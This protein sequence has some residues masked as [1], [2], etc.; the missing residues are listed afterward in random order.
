M[1][2]NDKEELDQLTAP[3]EV[4]NRPVNDYFPR[5]NQVLTT[6]QPYKL[7]TKVNH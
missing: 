7:I 2:N 6:A 4:V 5:E 3:K 1:A